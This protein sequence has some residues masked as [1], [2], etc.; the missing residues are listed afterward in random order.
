MMGLSCARWRQTSSAPSRCCTGWSKAYLP[1]LLRLRRALPPMRSTPW[2]ARSAP[3][4][5][6]AEKCQG[7]LNIE[8]RDAD[9][10]TTRMSMTLR[11]RR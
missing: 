3:A 7:E 10:S 11:A 9:G 6:M 1:A 2:P 4:L 8:H 5:P